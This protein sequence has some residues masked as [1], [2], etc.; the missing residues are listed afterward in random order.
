MRPGLQLPYYWL[1]SVTKALAVNLSRPYGRHGWYTG[2][3][4]SNLDGSEY[5]KT[6]SCY[7]SVR[8]L[9]PLYQRRRCSWNSLSND[10]RDP[11]L[12]IASFSRLLKM[13]LFQ[14]YSAH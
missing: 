4:G 12:S 1:K 5:H 3:I 8:N 7:L 11:E 14:Q 6:V 9:L 13:R 10:L 2:L